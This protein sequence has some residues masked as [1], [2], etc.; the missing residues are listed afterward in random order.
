MLLRSACILLLTVTTAFS[1]VGFGPFMK[2]EF[3]TSQ[4]TVRIMLHGLPSG[5][6]WMLAVK[7]GAA[8]HLQVMKVRV[9]PFVMQEWQDLRTA[10]GLIDIN[11]LDTLPG[12]TLS[13]NME[14]PLDTNVSVQNDSAVLFTRRIDGGLVVRNGVVQ[15]VLIASRR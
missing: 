4:G 7:I 14:V 10:D 5:G 12:Y 1:Q 6:D 8:T 15:P 11:G 13:I 9:L 3:T 2:H